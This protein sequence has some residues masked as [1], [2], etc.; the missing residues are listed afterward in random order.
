M[1]IV[2]GRNVILYVNDGS[3][4]RPVCCAREASLD[5]E[6]STDETSTD[7]TGIW[8][9][10]RGMRMGWTV[11]GSGIVS[12]DT[13][14]T[15]AE[16]RGFQFSFTPL[17]ISFEATDANGLSEVYQ[18]FV[19]IQNVGTS[20]THNGL[21]TY[22][23]TAQGTGELLI[24]DTPVDPNEREGGFMIYKYTGTGSETGGN[25]LPAIP[26]LAGKTVKCITRDGTYY[27][28]VSSS[29]VEK[30]FTFNTGTNMVTFAEE[31]PPIQSGEMIDIFYTSV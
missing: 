8:R 22:N 25:V 31:L 29:P 14:M 11:T 30:Q 5:T 4:Y 21:F 17:Y 23:F 28:L 16:L 2:K 27:R 7:D 6:T 12:L 13:N 10:Y 24:T 15:I 20:A 1:S 3:E 19:I 9:T 26:D 18:G